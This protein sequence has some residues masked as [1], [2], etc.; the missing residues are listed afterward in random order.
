MAGAG[1]NSRPVRAAAVLGMTGLL[2]AA[3]GTLYS[4]GSADFAGQ[5]RQPLAFSHA[6]HAG[7]LKID[8]LFCHRTAPTRR[9]PVDENV[10]ELPPE[11]GE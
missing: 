1:I 6:R 8:C 9:H 10:H 4:M 5:D 11:R 7:D 3:V 2:A